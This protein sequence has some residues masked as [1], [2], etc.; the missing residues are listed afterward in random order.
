MNTRLKYIAFICLIVIAQHSFSQERNTD[1]VNYI[2]KA[3]NAVKLSL[4]ELAIQ[5]YLSA[6]DADS[7][8][9]QAYYELGCLYTDM[10]LYTLAIPNF[11]SA[12][13]LN[14]NDANSHERLAYIYTE[15]EDYERAYTHA[16]KAIELDPMLPSPYATMGVYYCIKK[17]DVHES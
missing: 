10:E 6:I 5:Y 13:S 16:Q 7:S 2:E 8:S 4:N 3:R 11:M 1:N 9:A 15:N 17:E 14:A 12:L